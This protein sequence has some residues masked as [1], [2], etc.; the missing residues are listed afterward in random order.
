MREERFDLTSQRLVFAA[1]VTQE[2]RALD[3][4]TGRQL[5]VTTLERR[6]NADAMTYQG[7]NGKQYVAVAVTD[8]LVAFALP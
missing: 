7:A 1:R 5:W 2:R 8:T 4:K 6:G 3:A